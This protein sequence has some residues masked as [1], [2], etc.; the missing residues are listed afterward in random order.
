[1]SMKSENYTPNF[2]T[3]ICECCGKETIKKARIRDG[4]RILC[5]ECRVILDG[6]KHVSKII[7]YESIDKGKVMAL[8]KAKRSVHWIAEDM[9]TTD[10]IIRRIIN[11]QGE[12]R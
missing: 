9:F 7:P 11:E 2:F 10:D 5:P 6:G 12:K 1:M 4:L 8:H 3:Y